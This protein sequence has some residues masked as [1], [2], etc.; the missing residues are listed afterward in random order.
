MESK[1]KI[2][3]LLN[4]YLENGKYYVVDL[5]IS[6][7]KRNPTLVLLIDSDEGISIDECAKISRQLGND[8]EAEN[9]FE[10]AFVLEVSSPGVDT[11]IADSRQY[12]KNI[13]R[14]LK[15]SLADGEKKIGKLETVT[16]EGI[17]IF[18]EVLKGKLKSI[19]KEATFVPFNLIKLAQVQV[20]FA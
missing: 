15:I 7:S 17:T 11:P 2:Q 13:G 5:S 19:K 9:V 1:G 8:I 16:E 14:S 3:E 4:P 18:E 10:T 20:S 6:S 12:A